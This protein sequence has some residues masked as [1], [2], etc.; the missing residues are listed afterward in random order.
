MCGAPPNPFR[1]QSFCVIIPMYNEEGAAETCVRR[2][3]SALQVVPYRSALIIVNDGSL[4][5]TGEILSALASSVPNLVV[6]QHA[7]NAGY[8]AALRTGVERARQEAYDYALFMDS[9]MTND[10]ADI[11]RFVE[12]MEQGTDVIKASRYIPGGGMTGVPF[13]RRVISWTGNIIARTLFGMGLSDCTNGFRAVKIDVLSRMN[14]AENGFPIIV[15][16]LTTASS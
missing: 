14:L 11:V 16:E 2:V 3:C 13:A 4:D 7:R 15:E 1:L 12:K 5:R 10:P 6:V 9:D 8:G